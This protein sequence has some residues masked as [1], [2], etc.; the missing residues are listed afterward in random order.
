M[1]NIHLGLIDADAF[2]VLYALGPFD[3]YERRWAAGPSL[4]WI[5]VRDLLIAMP[6]S[7][8]LLVYHLQG[9]TKS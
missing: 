8:P 6:L 9:P 5:K 7:K 2:C 4:V 3:T 1:Q